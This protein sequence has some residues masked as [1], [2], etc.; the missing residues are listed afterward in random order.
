MDDPKERLLFLYGRGREL[1]PESFPSV[2]EMLG[3][4]NGKDV[5]E[6]FQDA[7]K[8]DF[9]VDALTLA[10]LLDPESYKLGRLSLI[11]LILHL[12]HL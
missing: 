10:Q 6:Q 2:S 7:L 11:G 4:V 3:N 8:K 5:R 1:D 12:N 9:S